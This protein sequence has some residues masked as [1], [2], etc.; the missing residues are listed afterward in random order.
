MKKLIYLFILAIGFT[1]C[2]VESIDSTENLLV[3][4]LKAKA[5]NEKAQFDIPT[6]SY[7]EVT[8]NSLQ[9]IVTAGNNGATGGI[10]VRWMTSET[11][12]SNGWDNALAGHVNLK[13]NNNTIIGLNEEGDTFQFNLENYL[14]PEGLEDYNRN[15]ECGLSYY[16]IVQA[17]QHGQLGKSDY[18]TPQLFSTSSCV[19]VCAYGKGY[20]TNHGPLNPGNQEDAYPNGGIKIGNTYY[21]L[22]ALQSILQENGNSG[23]VFKMKQHLITVLLN[24]ANGVDGSSMDDIIS[25]ANAI[26]V[27]NGDGYSPQDINNAKDAL[28]AFNKGKACENFEEQ[29][30]E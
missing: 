1:S 6:L 27:A 21:E 10:S 24:I 9:I 4:D 19:E 2:S 15:L 13:D 17:S 28:E 12:T 14:D 22:S 3:A 8:E 5:Q 18:S 23:G 29:E 26:I 30:E 16:F 11:Y 20:W 7:G 25:V